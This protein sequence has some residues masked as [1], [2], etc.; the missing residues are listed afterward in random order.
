M[1]RNIL[2]FIY[3]QI[4]SPGHRFKGSSTRAGV[5]HF[6]VVHQYFHC[7]KV[8]PCYVHVHTSPFLHTVTSSSL[9]C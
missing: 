4:Y 6:F 5:V 3:A 8:L 7:P 2:T 1:I 9:R